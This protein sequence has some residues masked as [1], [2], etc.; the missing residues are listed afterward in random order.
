MRLSDDKIDQLAAVIVDRLL[1]L[2]DE[3]DS[4]MV[5]G[6]DGELRAN[7]RHSLID[8]LRRTRRQFA[9]A[10]IVEHIEKRN[11]VKLLKH[12]TDVLGAKSGATLGTEVIRI[13]SIDLDTTIVR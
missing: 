9:N 3:D 2:E 8:F 1:A 5:M 12:K 11:Q 10:N 7:I 4:I 6:E 13:V